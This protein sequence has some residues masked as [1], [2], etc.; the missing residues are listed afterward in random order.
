[1]DDDELV[2][3]SL[4]LALKQLNFRVLAA[5]SGTKAA[6]LFTHNLRDVDLVITDLAMP[7]MQGAQ[8]IR[9]LRRIKPT[10]R[11]LVMTGLGPDAAPERSQWPELG[12]VGL[13]PKP[14]TAD[15]LL[16]LVNQALAA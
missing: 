16:R 4:R 15:E 8:L 3:D 1:M 11:V 13:L 9:L 12:I 6:S 7:L 10:I 14:T 2:R 5:P